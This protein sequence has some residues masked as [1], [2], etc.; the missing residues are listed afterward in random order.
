MMSFKGSLSDSVGK[1]NL[2]GYLISY[3]I[4]S[5]AARLTVPEEQPAPLSSLQHNSAAAHPTAMAFF[6]WLSSVQ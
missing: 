4:F 5:F 1:N 3:V 6:Q 2:V